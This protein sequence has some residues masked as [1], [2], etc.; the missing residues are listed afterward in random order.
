M[1]CR[2]IWILDSSGDVVAAGMPSDAG[3]L[4]TLRVEA[5]RV[6]EG[7]EAMEVA[8]GDNQWLMLFP[9][10]SPGYSGVVAL[11]GDREAVRVRQL[12]L[13]SMVHD[14]TNLLAVVQ[15][16]LDLWDGSG[17][18]AGASL[19]EALW[20]LAR[21]EELLSHLARPNREPGGLTVVRDT[22]EHLSSFLAN[23]RYPVQWIIEGGIPPVLVAPSDFV[24]IFHNLLQNACD[25]MPDGGPLAIEIRSQEGQVEITVR[26]FGAGIAEELGPKIFRPYFTTK[27]SGRGLGLYRARQLVEQYQ[28]RIE[29]ASVVGAGTRF[30]V[31]LP[32]FS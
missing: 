21:A 19:Q 8:T 2:G 22:L 30:I 26:D 24:E 23:G 20:T 15:G 18:R 11:W 12:K 25:A 4:E 28:G 14:I 32:S 9:L 10:K 31:T 17:E 27:S 16:H 1:N 13:E 3:I 29:V 6:F 5:R 7:N